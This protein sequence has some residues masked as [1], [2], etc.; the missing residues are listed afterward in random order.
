MSEPLEL[1]DVAS[2]ALASIILERTADTLLDGGNHAAAALEALAENT[3]LSL[4]VSAAILV[5][6]AWLAGAGGIEP[7]AVYA[8]ALAHQPDD[9]EA[10]TIDPQEA[11]RATA[12]AEPVADTRSSVESPSEPPGGESDEVTPSG[13]DLPVRVDEDGIAEA[14]AMA[15]RALATLQQPGGT[16][17]VAP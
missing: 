17:R 15:A 11:P 9:D 4:D 14:Q 10:P 16:D 13:D 7:E 12:D 5:A 1:D 2:R 6:T 3:G 8:A